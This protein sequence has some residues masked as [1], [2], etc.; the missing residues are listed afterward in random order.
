VTVSASLLRI[1]AVAAWLISFA[2]PATGADSPDAASATDTKTY[3]A[4]GRVLEVK[5]GEPTLVIEHDAITN[6][7]S[8]MTMPFHVKEA[9]Q[10]TGLK[11][12]DVISFRLN[13]T[14]T[15]SWIDRIVRTGRSEP[16][17]NATAQAA[18]PGTAQSSR[19]RNPLLDYAFTNE[20]GQPVR[21]SDFKGQALAIT[22][23]FTRCPIPD[24]CPRLSKNFQAATQKLSGMA[25]APTNWHFLSVTFDPEFDRP[26]VLK[27]YAETYQY[28]PKHWSFLTGP[29]DKIRELAAGSD[30]SYQPENGLINHNFRTLIIDAAG[31]LQT[32]F[33]TSGDLSEAIVSEV[34]KAAA[35]TNR[36]S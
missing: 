2:S 13:V 30:V 29:A 14:E 1:L 18:T 24:F 12:G 4:T 25:Q 16:A 17:G 15:E 31:H 36:S 9:E 28:D 20:L 3:S 11:S 22:F 7:M 27:A 32:V 33:P 6:Y 21:I 10:L 35:V 8:A 5:T 23:F 34:L 26:A 19:P